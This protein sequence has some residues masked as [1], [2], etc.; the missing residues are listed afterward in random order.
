VGLKQFCRM[1]DLA[2]FVSRSWELAWPMTLIM[3][4]EFLISLTDVYVAGKISKEVQAAYGF[5]AQIYFISIVVANAL[6]VGTVSVVS[7]LFADEGPSAREN[8]NLAV[9][10]SMVTAVVAGLVVLFAGLVSLPHVTAWLNIP[11]A[12]KTYV[13]PLSKI[14]LVGIVFHYGLINGNGVLR[15]CQMVRKSLKTMAVVCGCNI[16]L[17]FVFVFHTSLG[18][19]GIALATATSVTLGSLLNLRYLKAFTPPF[20]RFSLKVVKSIWA[21]GWPMGLL[22]VLWQLGSAALFLILSMLPE[23]RVE[24]LAAFTAGMRI[25]SAIFLPAFAFN[26]ANAVI[27]GNLLGQKNEKEAFRNGIVTAG[28][29]VAVVTALTI[30]VIL[31][32]KWIAASLSENQTVVRESIRYIYI[33]MISEPFM[34]WGI[35]LG[36]GLGGAGDT[37]AVMLRVAACVW[38][39][40]IPLCYT[41]VAILGFG[42]SSVWWAMNISQFVQALLLSIRYLRKG[43]LSRASGR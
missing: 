39:V 32:A 27:V 2:C 11:K 24:I 13:L 41:S 38:L 10:S 20:K 23:Q 14:Y 7:R 19:R 22:Q 12:V 26:M 3:F 17:I 16:F 40:R 42:A 25:E 34:A 18:Y 29:G 33:S 36:G 6:T 15:S 43:W 21:I 30:F 28:V 31:N 5:V 9:F 1:D 4:F 37:R 8:L 35:I